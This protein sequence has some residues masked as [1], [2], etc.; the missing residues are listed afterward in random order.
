MAETMVYTG[1]KVCGCIVTVMVD[2]PEHRKENAK[3]LGRWHRK[4][5]A[6]ERMT[7]E[8]VREIELGCKCDAKKVAKQVSLI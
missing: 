5:F 4:G 2:A 6:I 3:E 1:R 8:E 7:V